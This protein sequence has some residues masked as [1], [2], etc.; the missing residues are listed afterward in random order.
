MPERFVESDARASLEEME[1]PLC[2]STSVCEIREK[3]FETTDVAAF[4]VPPE[5][6][7]SEYRIRR[8]AKHPDKRVKHERMMNRRYRLSSNR[9]QS[10]DG[11]TRRE[12]EGE[13]VAPC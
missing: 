11:T 4:P 6:T 9:Q 1:W 3:G 12:R 2:I 7:K 8:L 5:S 10:M 13:C